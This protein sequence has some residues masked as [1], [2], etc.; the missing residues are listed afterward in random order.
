MDYEVVRNRSSNNFR[1]SDTALAAANYPHEA[2]PKPSI[3]SVEWQIVDSEPIRRAA[4]LVVKMVQQ[5]QRTRAWS[6]GLM[7][8][9]RSG[10]TALGF[11]VGWA[12]GGVIGSEPQGGEVEAC[13]A[14]AG[15]LRSS[16]S[17]VRRR[18]IGAR[19]GCSWG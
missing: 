12:L 16:W 11:Q 7:E 9:G 5:Q 13:A 19:R 4:N 1:L 18:R 3:G 8:L 6:W 14:V 15:E 17:G 2:D 10:L